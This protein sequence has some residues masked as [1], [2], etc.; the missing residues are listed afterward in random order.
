M[1]KKQQ[2]ARTH[3]HW[4]QRDRNPQRKNT[5]NV[6]SKNNVTEMKNVFMEAVIERKQL[7]KESLSW[8][9]FS[10]NL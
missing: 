4:K 6:E 10:R 9:Y 1:G 7:R 2:H 3:G 8:G 5:E